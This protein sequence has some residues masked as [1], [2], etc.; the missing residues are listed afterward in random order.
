MCDGYIADD[1]WTYWSAGALS[2]DARSL[3]IARYIEPLNR[4][5]DEAA[6]NDNWDP[7]NTYASIR[8]RAQTFIDEQ[9]PN[10]CPEWRFATDD[11]HYRFAPHLNSVYAKDIIE[12]GDAITENGDD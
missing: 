6:F 4:E 7:E 9:G 2:R 1:L 11:D 12:L 10:V 8:T 5:S 3:A